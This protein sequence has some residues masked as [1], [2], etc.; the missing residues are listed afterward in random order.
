MKQL[1]FIGF[2]FCCCSVFSQS[3]KKLN[4]QLRAE[5][6]LEQKNQDSLHALF[7]KD[8]TYLKSLRQN[9]EEKSRGP[10]SQAESKVKKGL[11]STQ[12]DAADLKDL[13]FDPKTIITD[14]LDTYSRSRYLLEPMREALNDYVSF[15][16]FPPERLNWER[17]SGLKEQNML[18]AECVKGLKEYNQL[19]LQQ[20]FL[21]QHHH[22]RELE[23]L[24]PLVDTLIVHYIRLGAQ[25][26]S[27]QQILT[28]KLNELGANYKQ[29]GPKG[30]PAAYK[31]VFPGVHVVI[32][33][34]TTVFEIKNPGEGE[35]I[36]TVESTMSVDYSDRNQESPIFEYVDE[37]AYFPEG[38]DALKKYLEENIRYPQAA[39]DAWISGKAFVR[40]VVSEKGKISDVIVLRGVTGCKECDQ[41]ARRLIQTMPDWSPAKNKGR[42]VR[43]YFTLPVWFKL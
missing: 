42:I 23:R 15:N 9:M 7:L 22:I 6:A 20:N 31:R 8:E 25:L 41:E 37:P 28:N 32:P 29:K 16:L 4:K 43:S 36:G 17:E 40:F 34:E 5:L 27:R 39:K 10:L 21:R 38:R 2:I 24:D 1:V 26:D 35:H 30:F 14:S 18:L 19:N 12:K 33:K 13:G 11:S 3:A